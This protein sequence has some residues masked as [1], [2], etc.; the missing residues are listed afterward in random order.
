[1]KQSNRN[2]KLIITALLLGTVAIAACSTGKSM[3]NVQSLKASLWLEDCQIASPGSS[4]SMDACCGQ[5]PVYEDPAAGKVPKNKFDR[6][7]CWT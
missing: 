7:L 4:E 1:M 5:L 6:R 3:E 2:I